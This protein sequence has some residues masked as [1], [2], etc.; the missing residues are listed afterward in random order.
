MHTLLGQTAHARTCRPSKPCAL[1]YPAHHPLHISQ[2]VLGC[3]GQASPAPCITLRIVHGTQPLRSAHCV[4]MQ[5]GHVLAPPK[6]RAC[7]AGAEAG[8]ARLHHEPAGQ[9]RV[10]ACLRT[11]TLA[12]ARA[13]T[14]TPTTLIRLR[15]RT[16]AGWRSASAP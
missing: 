12:R 14:H 11:C 9:A 8:G 16:L 15:A 3:A 5:Q 1:Q 7:A 10:C 13:L 2:S 4:L 6:P